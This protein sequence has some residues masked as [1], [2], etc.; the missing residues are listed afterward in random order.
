MTTL[1]KLVV[2][3]MTPLLNIVETFDTDIDYWGTHN[4]DFIP[5]HLLKRMNVFENFQ[6]INPPI[7]DQFDIKCIYNEKSKESNFLYT[8]T[9]MLYPNYHF[10]FSDLIDKNL[11]IDLIVSEDLLVKIRTD[12][13]ADFEKYMKTGLINI[14]AYNKKIDFLFF[15]FTE[16]NLLIRL[17]KSN[18]DIDGKLLLFN[19]NAKT[20][21]WAEEL[22]NYYLKDSI[23]VTEL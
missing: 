23:P 5:D 21:E 18:G 4:F 20:L 2:D 9:A 10:V 14:Y 22:F 12:Y 17:L 6:I 15:T 3:D 19:I 11:K 1:G 8:V 13:H 7:T 16:D